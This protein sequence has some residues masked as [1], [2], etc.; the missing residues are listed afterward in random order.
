MVFERSLPVLLIVT[1][2]LVLAAPAAASFDITVQD[3]TIEEP[4]ETGDTGTAAVMI[5]VTSTQTMVC[6]N[7]GDFNLELSA[8]DDVEGGYTG[9]I[10]STIT[11]TVPTGVYGAGAAEPWSSEEESVEF[12]ATLGQTV[13]D[14]S[15]RYT[16]NAVYPG[17]SGPGDC[18]AAE[19]PEASDSGRVS[20]SAQES[21][22]EENDTNTTDDGDDNTEESP[23]PGVA[24][25]LVVALAVAAWRRR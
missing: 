23:A 14:S 11:F 2:L 7:G 9:D 3:A 22:D 25:V 13:A 8:E 1:A 15:F 6:P 19:W 21:N 18:Q 5:S 12:T 20:V 16:I 24:V 17:G 4:I 10:P